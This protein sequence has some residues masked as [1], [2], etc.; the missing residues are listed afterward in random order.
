MGA[1]K[2]RAVTNRIE[3]P[4]LDPTAMLM[5]RSLMLS[6]L[7]LMSMQGL[8]PI[9]IVAISHNRSSVKEANTKRL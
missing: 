2:K 1:K 5:K 9:P 6:A 4:P 7:G 3:L 8:L